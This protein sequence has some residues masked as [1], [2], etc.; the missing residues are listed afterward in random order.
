MNI[1]TVISLCFF[2]LCFFIE[3]FGG[4]VEVCVPEVNWDGYWR[5]LHV[6]S[7]YGEFDVNEPVLID[8]FNCSALLRIKGV[9]QY[10]FVKYL[11]PEVRSYSRY[12]HCVGVWAI[13]RLF[14]GSLEEQILALLHDVSH[15]VFSHIGDYLKKHSSA[16]RGTSYQDEIHRSFLIAMGVDL[17]L[18]RHGYFLDDILAIQHP[19][20][21]QPSPELCADRLEY[22]LQAGLLTVNHDTDE[23]LLSQADVRYILNDLRFCKKS[24]HWFFVNQAAAKK[25]AMVSLYTTEYVVGAAWNHVVYS[26]AADALQEALNVYALNEEQIHFSHDDVVWGILEKSRNKTIQEALYKVKH[27]SELLHVCDEGEQCD[28]VVHTKF[29]GINP[30]VRL[31][32]GKEMR[33]LTEIDDDF[34]VEY[35]RVKAVIGDGWRVKFVGELEGFGSEQNISTVIS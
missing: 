27:Y 25:F 35:D 16:L 32:K 21:E 15:T 11:H 31:G 29:R 9:H 1:R 22:T 33:H 26:W 4:G 18:A 8:L 6:S 3:S 5:R 19:I 23:V 30:L 24:K 20:L 28:V 7:I 17:I 13:V 2:S 14:G 12:N 10:G 34:D